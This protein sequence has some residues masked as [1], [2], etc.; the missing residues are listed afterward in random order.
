MTKKPL[1]PASRI[2]HLERIVQA[3]VL[4]PSQEELCAHALLHRIPHLH[5]GKQGAPGE[6]AEDLP[7]PTIVVDLAVDHFILD[8]GTDLA[9]K[10][11]VE[12]GD[13]DHVVTILAVLRKERCPAG[14]VRKVPF[15]R[16]EQDLRLIDHERIASFL[17]PLV[18]ET[19][20]VMVAGEPDQ[21]LRRH[22]VIV[23]AEEDTALFPFDGLPVKLE[24]GDHHAPV[25]D[26]AVMDVPGKVEALAGSGRA[27]IQCDHGYTP[28]SDGLDPAQ[29]D[30]VHIV[31]RDCAQPCGT[32]LQKPPHGHKPVDIA[33]VRQRGQIIDH[34]PER[35]QRQKLQHPVQKLV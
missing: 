22:A 9:V 15:P 13:Q 14:T 32:D 7:E 4:F 19:H 25:I 33:Q 34:I 26:Q 8:Q 29:N 11:P 30:A 5:G 10:H 35:G 12:L 27:G 31:T 3:V 18:P 24:V 21:A 28:L 16:I 6:Q 20:P 23:Y 2:E 17:T 1:R